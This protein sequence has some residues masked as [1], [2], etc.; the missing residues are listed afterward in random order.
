[1]H[2]CW[3]VQGAVTLMVT[4]RRKRPKPL[5]GS[6]SVAFVNTFLSTLDLERIGVLQ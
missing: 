4:T 3:T 2:F 5:W 6:T 1:M